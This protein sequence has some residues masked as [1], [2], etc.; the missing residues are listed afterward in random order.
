MNIY[1]KSLFPHISTPLHLNLKNVES[2]KDKHNFIKRKIL[3]SQLSRTTGHAF[4]KN[5]IISKIL[6]IFVINQKVKT[7]LS[8]ISIIIIIQ[9]PS[10]ERHL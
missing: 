8:K 2:L 7:L 1:S 5:T 6:T 10:N 9:T 3:N 4:I